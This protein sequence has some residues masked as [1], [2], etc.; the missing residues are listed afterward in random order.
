MKF[1]LHL[2]HR[3]AHIC[4]VFTHSALQS[5]APPRSYWPSESTF[6]VDRSSFRAQRKVFIIAR[7]SMLRQLI[8]SRCSSCLLGLACSGV[9]LAAEVAGGAAGRTVVEEAREERLKEAAKDDL[10]AAVGK[11]C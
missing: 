7:L 10:G 6:I 8:P 3:Y 1:S 2:G 5:H 11:S 9:S 4:S